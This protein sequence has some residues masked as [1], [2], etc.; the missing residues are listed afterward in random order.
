MLKI[1]VFL[2]ALLLTSFC[3]SQQ[4]IQSMKRLPDSGQKLSY[5]NTYG[6][7]NDYNINSPFYINN[8]DG[9]ITDTIT[10]LMW[11][12]TDGGEITFENAITYTDTLTLGGFNNWRL[13][14]AHE[15]FSI[16]NLQN[17][18]PALDVSFFTKTPAEYWWTSNRQINDST[19]IWVTNAGG[20]IGNHPKSE[21]ISAGGTK[22][23]HVRAVRDIIAPPIFTTVYS[24]NL[25][26]T[27][28]DN[29]TNLVWQKIPNSNPMTWEA[30]LQYAENLTLGNDSNWRLP[31]IKE[32]QSLN[33][34]S[35]VNPS[36]NP[37]FFNN[38]GVRK[39]WSS[40]TQQNQAANAWY[41]NT[42]YGITTYD[43][44]SNNNFV[45]CVRTNKASMASSIESFSMQENKAKVFPNPFVDRIEITGFDNNS[46]FCL[47][48]AAGKIIFEGKDIS[49]QSF[50]FLNRG[51]YFIFIT[52][53]GFKPI[54][55][56][57]N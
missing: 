37:S 46:V 8:N 4:V 21:T 57:K 34:E 20:G 11:Q 42:Q 50:A 15:A 45:L 18:N 9:T 43:A 56:I 1:N 47:L 19:K 55:L 22:K 16:L 25:N 35:Y 26:G 40:T 53:S 48:D 5:T 10:G 3:Y 14:N 51:V 49:S 44:K 7:D 17:N 27:I 54:K 41:W 6:E 23:V 36:V 32:L 29:R 33:D 38:M 31:N 2:F 12:K 24:D 28:T 39:Y 13:P 52:N 30:A